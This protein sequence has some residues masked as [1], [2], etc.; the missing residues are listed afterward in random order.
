LPKNFQRRDPIE[1]AVASQG[2]ADSNETN[3]SLET[4]GKLRIEEFSAKR[5]G[6][7]S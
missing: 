1:R 3:F 4:S 5:N 2:E 7:G 6:D